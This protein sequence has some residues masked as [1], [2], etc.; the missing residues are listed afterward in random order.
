MCFMGVR[1]IGQ[2]EIE[3]P[4]GIGRLTLI[5]FWPINPDL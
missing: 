2:Y 1:S 4:G 3:S 5:A